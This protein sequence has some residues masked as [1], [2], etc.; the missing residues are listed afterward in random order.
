MLSSRGES[1]RKQN[2]MRVT[3]ELPGFI[4]YIQQKKLRLSPTNNNFYSYPLNINIVPRK[5]WKNDVFIIAQHGFLVFR[6]QHSMKNWIIID[7]TTR[8]IGVNSL[9]GVGLLVVNDDTLTTLNTKNKNP[10]LAF[11]LILQ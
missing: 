11:H 2:S 3:K 9:A 1:K 7:S 5:H 10:P 6:A 8:P 4:H